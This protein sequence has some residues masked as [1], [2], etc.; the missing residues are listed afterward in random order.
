M[1]AIAPL[2]AFLCSS[3]AQALAPIVDVGNAKYQGT[4]NVATNISSY[5]GIRYAAAP[6]GDL[7]FRAPQSPPVLASVQQATNKPQQCLQAGAGK[8][9]TNPNPTSSLSER[10]TQDPEDCLF[11]KYVPC[12][13]S[14]LRQSDLIYGSV[15]FPGN[16]I[17]SHLLPVVVWIH[18]GG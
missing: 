18:G 14:S 17:P 5:F 16:T 11:L 12:L 13:A 9:P 3:V 10:A 8:S 4:V 7:R 15:H 6:V 2:L 1:R